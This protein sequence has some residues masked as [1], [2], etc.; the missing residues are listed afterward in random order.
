MI[1]NYKKASGKAG[2]TYNCTKHHLFI[3]KTT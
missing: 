2:M 1:L 3:A